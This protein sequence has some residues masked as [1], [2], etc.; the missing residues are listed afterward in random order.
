[1]PRQTR[2]NRQRPLGR[3]ADLPSADLRTKDDATL[4]LAA[5]QAHVAKRTVVT[6]RVDVRTVTDVVEDHV[7]ATVESQTVEVTHVTIDRE[8]AVA[9]AIR[10]EGDTT[11]IPVL[12]EVLVIEKRLVLKEEIRIRRV[13]RSEDVETT[14]Q[15][16]RQRAV[17]ERHDAGST[18][19][20][21]DPNAKETKHEHR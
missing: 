12:E 8:V 11:I 13:S 21:P 7:A 20:A 10:T 17:V 15:L 18:S 2:S 5:E 3:E 19:D 4:Q 1:M 14:V 6:G 16:R 9:P